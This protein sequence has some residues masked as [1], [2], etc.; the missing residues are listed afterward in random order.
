MEDGEYR[1]SFGKTWPLI[2]PPFFML[3][4]AAW[5]ACQ[6]SSRTGNPAAMP[7]VLFFA[8]A[9][10]AM[11][12]TGFRV[13]RTEYLALSGDGIGYTQTGKPHW[14]LK[15]EEIRAVRVT[16]DTSVESPSAT[17]ILTYAG[18]ERM[19]R[20]AFLPLYGRELATEICLRSGAQLSR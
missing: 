5:I 16:R 19:I 14:H 4:V 20:D 13:L 12:A 1:A 18:G 15:W 17:V 9:A 10:L 7:L 6:P 2:V 3:V 8:V 11:I